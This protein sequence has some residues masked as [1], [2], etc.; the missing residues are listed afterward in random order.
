MDAFT[1]QSVDTMGPVS[2]GTTILA[3]KFKGGVVLAAD[4]RTSTGS[5]V[6]DRWAKKITQIA[7]NVFVCRSGSAS[8]TQYVAELA[9]HYL[10]LQRMERDA[11]PRV[12]TAVRILQQLCYSNR[13]NLSAGLIVAGYDDVKGAQIYNIN[14][15][16][17]VVEQDIS[18]GGSGSTYIFSWVDKMYKR[19]MSQEEALEFAKQAVSH[20]ISRDGG[21]GGI[22]R[23]VAV[24][25][26][27]WKE[28]YT[29]PYK[30]LAFA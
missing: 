20:A 21:S 2:M 12:E 27:E 22:V 28:Q 4:T 7:P 10:N 6:F 11:P 17:A 15:G 9:K 23:T 1:Q 8:D 30:K 29:E 13:N 18:M 16:G 14:L 5:Y 25:A 3:C 19:E 24:T 26:N